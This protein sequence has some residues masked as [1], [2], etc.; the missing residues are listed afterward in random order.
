MPF[1][2]PS[3]QL[4]FCFYFFRTIENLYSE[5]EVGI[6]WD[7]K[8]DSVSLFFDL[9]GELKKGAPARGREDDELSCH[10]LS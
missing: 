10:L 2:F 5:F 7:N 1:S 3:F 9:L 6:T 4:L 8:N